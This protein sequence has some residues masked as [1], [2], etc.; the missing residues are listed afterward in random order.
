V[1]RIELV[2]E[3]EVALLR[4]RL[5]CEVDRETYL[6]ACKEVGVEPSW[7]DVAFTTGDVSDPP[8]DHG[9]A[10]YTQNRCE[11]VLEHLLFAEELDKRFL[12][13]DIEDKRYLIGID[14]GAIDLRLLKASGHLR[15]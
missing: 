6:H 12:Y 4:L 1:S 10:L 3:E 5:E 8:S 7:N 11:M 15:K 13:M 14:E 2:P 9:R